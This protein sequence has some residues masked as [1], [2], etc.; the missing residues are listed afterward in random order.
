MANVEYI[1]PSGAEV[2]PQCIGED[3]YCEYC[4][5]IGWVTTN[6]ADEWRRQNG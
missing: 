2:C 3:D 6:Q 5:G 1:P 4:C